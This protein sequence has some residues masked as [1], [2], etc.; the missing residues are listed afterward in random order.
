MN[1]TATNLAKLLEMCETPAPRPEL[2][3][4]KEFIKRA[5]RL[6]EFLAE[7]GGGVDEELYGEDLYELFCTLEKAVRFSKQ[8]DEKLQRRIE[9]GEEG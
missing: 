8:A 7:T 3:L 9:D 5:K 6:I 1:I 2:L 4:R